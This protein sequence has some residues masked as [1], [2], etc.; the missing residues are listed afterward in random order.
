MT[1]KVTNFIKQYSFMLA[2]AATFVGFSA[3]KASN[4]IQSSDEWFNITATPNGDIN[5]QEDQLI[6]TDI[7]APDSTPADGQCRI[8]NTAE[9]CAVFLHLGAGTE[10]EDLDGMTV[11]EALESVE[12]DV[13]L[14]SGTG[15]GYAKSQYDE[16]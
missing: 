1:S 6:G 8:N 4:R 13:T 11:K 9:P 14:N 16:D 3:F 15:G 2:L 12:V 5:E 7:P 10:P